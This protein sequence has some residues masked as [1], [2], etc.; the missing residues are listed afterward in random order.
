MVEGEGKSGVPVGFSTTLPGACCGDLVSWPCGT[1]GEQVVHGELH[2]RTRLADDHHGPA[3]VL[4]G[5]A[6]LLAR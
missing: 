5:D 3:S 1:A 4:A 2:R 6:A